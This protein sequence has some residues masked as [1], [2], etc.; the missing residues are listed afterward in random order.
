MYKSKIKNSKISIPKKYSNL[1]L[2]SRREKELLNKKK[3]NSNKLLPLKINNDNKTITK[4]DSL[5]KFA[6]ETISSFK[7]SFDF[8]TTTQ[9]ETTS[10][11][12]S[13]KPIIKDIKKK[14]I[15]PYH[16]SLT[17]INRHIKYDNKTKMNIFNPNEISQQI[18]DIIIDSKSSNNNN[19][20]T[21]TN[22]NSNVNIL[23]IKE[24]NNKIDVL[25]K[26]VRERNEEKINKKFL[27]TL[28]CKQKK[29]E[30]KKYSAKDMLNK[31]RHLMYF[32][33][34]NDI[35]KENNIRL[36]ESYENKLEFVEDNI[37]TLN[38]G[39]TLYDVKFSNKLS[40]YVKYILH[41]KDEEK[42]KCDIQLS[43]INM[44]KKEIA[45]LQ[46]KI[47]KEQIERDNILKWIYFQIKM[48]EKKLIL[49]KYYKKIIETSIKRFDIRRK[50]IAVQ[51]TDLKMV[52]DTQ[53]THHHN[54]NKQKSSS[55]TKRSSTS[56]GMVNY[57][58][59]T[60]HNIH[61]N[62]IYS[63]SHLNKNNQSNNNH[64]H[65]HSHIFNN[66]LSNLNLN[67]Y[68][69]HRNNILTKP[70]NSLSLNQNHELNFEENVLS[71]KNLQKI[72]KNLNDDNIDADE[73][74][75]VSQYKLFL[76]YN[77]PDEFY[78]RLNEL[79]NENILLLKEYNVKQRQLNQLK[80]E[81]YLIYKDRMENNNGNMNL[82]K[83]REIE[84]QSVISRHELLKKQLSDI[85]KGK[86]L[87][88]YNYNY[89]YNN[90]NKFGS[91]IK[92]KN[93]YKNNSSSLSK[94]VL[95]KIENLYNKCFINEPKKK[96]KNKKK[97]N[98]IKEEII[99]ML[100]YIESC[101]DKLMTQ[102]RSY[103]TVGYSNYEL[104]KK[105]KNDIERKHKI[106]N[107]DMARIKEKE[108]FIK[109]QQEIENK[110][111]KI[112]FIQRRKVYCDYGLNYFGKNSKYRSDRDNQGQPTFE[113]FM[114]D[115]N[116]IYDSDN[117][118]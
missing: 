21:I 107:A 68:K 2:F 100:S 54:V 23:H 72:Q 61:N 114:F 89:N 50:T 112:I 104:M 97:I 70:K 28:N 43:D 34:T 4:N 48:K 78:E 7:F 15:F 62:N 17:D 116:E 25:K 101:I 41:Y 111:H 45:K 8:L 69:Q 73:I 115:K 59:G 55:G 82:L 5:T 16:P 12:K 92:L 99:Y 103:N 108:N 88:K 106:E 118:I 85:K 94:E 63:N 60:F 76:I 80:K 46:N 109:F 32:K 84:F 29:F 57:K 110:S 49:P 102:F 98:S 9:N 105:I 13:P 30:I 87:N 14:S 113:D 38:R 44:Y 67:K 35:K 56:I 53:T 27:L 10:S 39:K 33:F 58:L 37:K 40:E 1:Q 77:T 117:K 91:K 52:R 66:N 26:L 19:F 18:N 95:L 83:E 64:H 20:N 31:T 42:R 47:I 65:T 71:T 93:N 24:K 79:E 96:E 3:S 36:Q 86:Y 75:R 90:I 22:S 6:L 81:H 74:N 11:I 51:M